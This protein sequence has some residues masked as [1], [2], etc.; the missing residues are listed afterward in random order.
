MKTEAIKDCIGRCL[1][2]TATQDSIYRGIVERSVIEAR[3]ELAALEA[4]NVAMCE[5]LR[6]I[7]R[8]ASI[9]FVDP[10]RDLRTSLMEIHRTATLSSDH[11]GDA[12][13]KVLTCEWRQANL[14]YED[15]VWDTE[16]GSMFLFADGLPCEDG[17]DYC[18]YCGKKIVR[19]DA[20]PEEA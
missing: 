2:L 8:I 14:W 17:I 5:A 19:I 12:N 7:R 3:A 15:D 6:D 4:D 20:K 18:C 1:T 13:K 9:V 16:C 11:I 10:G